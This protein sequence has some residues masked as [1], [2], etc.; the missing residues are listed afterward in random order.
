VSPVTHF[1]HGWAL[2]QLLAERRDRIIVTI[3]A[4]VPDID[5]L[6]IIPE[7]LT[8]NSAHPLAG[9]SEYHHLL[10]HNLWAALLTTCAA[11]TC[12]R[13]K[14]MTALL[15]FISFHLHLMGDLLGSR[16]PDGYQW[17]IKYLYPLSATEWT[18]RG[19]WPLASWQNMVVTIALISFAFYVA[20]VKRITPVEVFS[21][22]ADEAVVKA[23]VRRV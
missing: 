12:A 4:V 21:T 23:I 17:P 8:R 19:Q 15:A 6:G 20:R 10:A 3:A 2:A 14:A 16:G 18:W 13:K 7:I 11:A 1:L 9:F 22:R 5:G